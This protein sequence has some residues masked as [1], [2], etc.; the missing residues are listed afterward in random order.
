MVCGLDTVAT[1]VHLPSR[2]HVD[3]K[4]HLLLLLLLLLLMLLLYGIRWRERV[5]VR[6]SMRRGEAFPVEALSGNDKKAYQPPLGLYETVDTRALP[7]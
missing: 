7:S 6:V 2:A 5:T 1:A 3:N 4:W